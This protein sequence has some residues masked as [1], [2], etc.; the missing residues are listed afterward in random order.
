ML[1]RDVAPASQ[2]YFVFYCVLP[3]CC[4]RH[5]F[6]FEVTEL[7]SANYAIGKL[8]TVK[9]NKDYTSWQ[10]LLVS[11]VVQIVSPARATHCCSNRVISRP[12]TTF[13]SP[14]LRLCCL[15]LKTCAKLLFTCSKYL[16]T[17]SPPKG[18]CLQIVISGE[19]GVHP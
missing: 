18:L 13:H 9:N 7:V 12:S 6:N 10:F 1:M 15:L 11:V 2:F 14:T 17:Q 8:D 3:R 16:R 5:H 4:F 19:T